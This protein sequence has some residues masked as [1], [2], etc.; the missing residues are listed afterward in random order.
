[1]SKLSSA[2]ARGRPMTDAV[3]RPSTLPI[4]HRRSTMLLAGG[5]RTLAA[6]LSQPKR[7]RGAAAD[8]RDATLTCK[9]R[10]F[11]RLRVRLVSDEGPSFACASGS[12]LKRPP[13]LMA[14]ETVPPAAGAQGPHPSGVTKTSVA[15]NLCAKRRKA[16]AQRHGIG[17][18]A[19]RN[20]GRSVPMSAGP[21]R[22][23]EGVSRACRPDGLTGMGAVGRRSA[24]IVR[25]PS[26]GRVGLTP[27]PAEMRR[28]GAK[29]RKRGHRTC[30][31]CPNSRLGMRLCE[32]PVSHPARVPNANLGVS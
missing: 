19:C 5:G 1:M 20:T 26:G 6:G 23:R 3:A 31:S 16:R 2:E 29:A 8:G 15:P 32:T 13:L 10:A 14:P 21:C 22:S 11:L 24:L 12:C 25:A 30:A 9:R 7:F 4:L 17:P 27:E 28:R 18:L